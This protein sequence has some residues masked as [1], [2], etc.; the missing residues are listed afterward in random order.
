[1]SMRTPP[2][3]LATLLL[4]PLLSMSV[5]AD[6]F[7]GDVPTRSTPQSTPGSSISYRFWV[8]QQAAFGLA[9]PDP[10]FSRDQAD[11][12]RFE[13]E[14]FGQANHRIGAWRLQASGA[15]I[16]D[17]LPDTRDQLDWPGYDFTDDQDD[18]RRW[19]WRLRDTHVSRTWGDLWLRGG[20]QTL[21]WG[22]AETLNVIDVAGRRDERWPGQASLDDLRLPVPALQAQW[23]SLDAVVFWNN[24]P[25][26]QPAAGDDFDPWTGLRNAGAEVKTIDADNPAGLALRWQHRWPGTDLQLIAADVNAFQP[27]PVEVRTEMIGGQPVPSELRLQMPR[28]RVL[29]AGLQHSRGNWVWRTEQAV[30]TDVPLVPEQPVAAWPQADQWRAMWGADFSGWRNLTLTGEAAL[31]WT[32]DRPADVRQSEWHWAQS[33]RARHQSFS[34][35]LTLEAQA[36]HLGADQGGLLRAGAQWDLS[37]HWNLEATGVAYVADD[38]QLLYSFRHQDAVIFRLRWLP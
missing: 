5:Q 1:M 26:R 30:H 20:Y 28:N 19:Q 8:Q 4:Y 33:L 27:A 3:L 6:D 10:G 13:T 31:T 15:L 38:D 14:L 34:E 12:T 25:H 17:W 37:D 21:A 32:P 16:H 18:A 23:H 22:E 7:F 11:W 9:N 36:A 24:Q 29:G 2:H 35:R